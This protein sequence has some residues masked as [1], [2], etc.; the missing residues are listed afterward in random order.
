MK[1][2]RKVGRRKHSRSS[3]I[4]RRR[5]RNKKSRSGYKKRYAKTHKGGAR[6]RKYGHK[7]GKRFHRGG[8]IGKIEPPRGYEHVG[9]FTFCTRTITDI[10]DTETKQVVNTE[11]GDAETYVFDVFYDITT[12]FPQDIL[13]KRRTGNSDK[14][15][16]EF[17]MDNEFR[18]NQAR[19]Q[20]IVSELNPA[21][22]LIVNG[23]HTDK[24]YM[25]PVNDIN[26]TSFRALIDK[27]K[28]INK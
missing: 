10:R 27:L 28:R 22:P 5:F 9:N 25:F 6:S 2:S 19:Y 11:Y 26:Q 4:S 14:Y 17:Y 8:V 18:Y 13:L 1:V 24:K 15:D 23:R 3:S 16:E 7:R 12:G 21:Q 20:N